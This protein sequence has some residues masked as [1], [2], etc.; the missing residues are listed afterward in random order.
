MYETACVSRRR[1][2]IEKKWNIF[3]MAISESA[4]LVLG[5]KKEQTT[6]VGYPKGHGASYTREELPTKNE[7][8]ATR[9]QKNKR[10]SC[11]VQSSGYASQK[12]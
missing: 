4:Q 9:E 12:G 5:R 7:I 8:R 3:R 11:L 6:K 1:S 2:K 10:R